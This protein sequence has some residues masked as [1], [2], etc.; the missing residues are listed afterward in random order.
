MSVQGAKQ[1]LQLIY[2]ACDAIEEIGGKPKDLNMSLRDLFKMDAHRYFMF[3]SASDGKVVPAERDYMNELFDANLSIQDY[4]KIINETN[5]YSVD[6][7]NDIPLCMKILALF[8]AKMDEIGSQ[9]GDS[10]PNLI[11]LS[12]DFYQKAGLEF[13]ACDRD[14]DKQEV[15]DLALYIAKKKVILQQIVETEN[16]EDVGIIGKK[17][18]L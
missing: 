3:L 4:V 18:G 5:T 17:K 1:L 2:K 16:F 8:D 11:P 12:L 13:I 14:V 6:F 7:E 10:F 15:E 9:L